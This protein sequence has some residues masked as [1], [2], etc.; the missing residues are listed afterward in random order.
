MV[1][2]CVVTEI[3]TRATG[4]AF[5]KRRTSQYLPNNGRFILDHL[6]KLYALGVLQGRD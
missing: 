5:A 4:K 1:F 3:V 2:L 6:L